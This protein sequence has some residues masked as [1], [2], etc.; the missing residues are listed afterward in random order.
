[1]PARKRTTVLALAIA[2]STVV[3]LVPA[4]VANAAPASTVSVERIAASAETT[5]SGEDVFRAVVF[6]ELS[7]VPELRGVFA[8]APQSETAFAL[9]DSIVADIDTADPAFFASFGSR[10][11][12]G[13]VREV[14]SALAD[15][16][17]VL[18]PLLEEAYA[19]DP[20]SVTPACAA[21]ISV[22]FFAVG[23]LVVGM[24]AVLIT[25]AVSTQGVYAT[26]WSVKNNSG[27]VDSTSTLS[28]EKLVVALTKVLATS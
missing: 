22:F 20:A 7:G 6:G 18:A 19:T 24:A 23:A 9:I 1:M 3:A 14:E 10:M 21:A 17:V 27:R 15:A 5:Y 12:S 16:G 2:A 11:Q 26:N 4:A 13:D 28:R 25:A 8:E